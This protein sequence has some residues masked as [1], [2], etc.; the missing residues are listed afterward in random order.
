LGFAASWFAVQGLAPQTALEVLDLEVIS[1]GNEYPE[2]QFS[3][4]ELA[5]GWTVVWFERDCEAAF[6]APVIMLAQQGP[7]VAC[8][9]EEHVMF[10]EARGYVDGKEIWR[11]TRNSEEADDL[12]AS[13]DL[14]P[15]YAAIRDAAVASQHE[16]GNDDVDLI[17]DVPPDLAK[18]ICGFRHDEQPDGGATFLELRRAKGAP[19]AAAP[20]TSGGFWRRLFGGR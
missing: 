8:G 9:V 20:A 12:E 13:G 10:S 7:A 1:E 5:N 6:R 2:G 3:L 15:A 18:S 14:P 19:G 4:V 17:W 11:V 16:D